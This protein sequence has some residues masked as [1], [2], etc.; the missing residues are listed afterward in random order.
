M[1]NVVMM[2]YLDLP[3]CQR[4]CSRLKLQIRN[5]CWNDCF[6]KFMKRNIVNTSFHPVAVVLALGFLKLSDRSL[7]N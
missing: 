5:G 6:G 3:T 1:C 2:N 7:K 4:L